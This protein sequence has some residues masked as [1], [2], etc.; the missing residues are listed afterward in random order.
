[1]AI[2]IVEFSNGG[3]KIRNKESTYL[4]KNYQILSF[5]LM[6]SCQTLPKFDFQSPENSSF[7]KI[8]HFRKF[9]I[10]EN[11]SFPKILSFPKLHHSRKFVIPENS[12]FLKICHS[13]KFLE[14]LRRKRQKNSSK[15][16]NKEPKVW[17]LVPTS[18]A[19]QASWGRA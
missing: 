6:A 13:W 12:S 5:G 18:S 1:M 11:L 2:R 4:K 8:R 9:V 16:E 7:P 17:I 19:C 14:K 10:P 3:Y 15:E